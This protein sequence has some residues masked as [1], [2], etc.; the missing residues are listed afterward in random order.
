MALVRVNI[1]NKQINVPAEGLN[2]VMSF[3]HPE[4]GAGILPQYL[5]SGSTLADEVQNANE[6]LK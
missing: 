1:R 3:E 6:T 2:S 4:C 5:D